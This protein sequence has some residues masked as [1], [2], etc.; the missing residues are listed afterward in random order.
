[1]AGQQVFWKKEIDGL[2]Y[3][4]SISHCFDYPPEGELM[5]IFSQNQHALYDLT[6]TIVPGKTIGSSASRVMLVANVQGAS[7]KINDIRRAMKACNRIAPPYV[8]VSAAESVAAALQINAIVGVSNKQHLWKTNQG[9]PYFV[10][11]YDEFWESFPGTRSDIG[12]YEISIPIPIK[13]LETVKSNQRRRAIRKRELGAEISRS[14]YRALSE[15]KR[16]KP[17]DASV[18]T[19]RR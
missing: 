9:P 17:I 3:T 11:D 4:I 12:L 15:L 2:N 18:L 10:F 7:G 1:M 5:L 6:F 13:P 19:I 8:L 14:V 16:E